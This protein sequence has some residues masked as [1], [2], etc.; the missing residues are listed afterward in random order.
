MNEM[1]Q[2]IRETRRQLTSIEPPLAETITDVIVILGSSRSGSTLLHKIISSHPEINSLPGEEQT[3]FNLLGYHNSIDDRLKNI[4]INYQELANEMLYDIGSK[5]EEISSNEI[6]RRILLQ[7]PE[8]LNNLGHYHFSNFNQ[9]VELLNL[10]LHFYE[11]N[12]DQHVDFHQ[13][14]YIIE[15][16]P[17]IYPTKM[18]RFIKNDRNILLLKSSSN[19]YRMDHVLKLFPSARYHFILLKRDFKQVI[20]GLYDGWNSSGF[21]SHYFPNRLNIP[22]YQSHSWWKFDLPPNWDNY[23]NH[24]LIDICTFQW[25]SNYEYILNF[26]S[27]KTFYSINYDDFFQIDTLNNKLNMFYEQLNIASLRHATLPQSMT[28]Y[29]P[30]KNRWEEKAMLIKQI[31]SQKIY[32]DLNHEIL[33]F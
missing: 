16:P 5:P 22:D 19:S 10:P 15:E 28:T 25:K 32:Q 8:H 18:N 31:S 1:L 12:L 11:N 4:E 30:Q 2:K 29:P 20:N 13:E 24:N 27:N 7:W 6:N 21:H 33:N 3:Y 26:L 9:A 14:H 17:F 23:L